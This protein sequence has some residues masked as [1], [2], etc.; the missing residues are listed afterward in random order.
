MY[1]PRVCQTDMVVSERL[2]DEKM[3]QLVYKTRKRGIAVW[4]YGQNNTVV[5]V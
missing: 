5:F 1:L 4:N 3:M 2:S